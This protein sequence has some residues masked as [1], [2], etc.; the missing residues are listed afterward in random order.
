MAVHLRLSSAKLEAKQALERHLK[1]L[2]DI[3][4]RCIV[5]NTGN[6]GFLYL[7]SIPI[8][9]AAWEGYF[10]IACSICLRRHCRPGQKVSSYTNIY[11]ALWLQKEGFLASFLQKLLNTMTLGTPPKKQGAGKFDVLTDFTGAMKT[12]LGSPVDHLIDFDA[13]VMTHSNVNKSVAELN[14]K[15]I[16]LDI[17]NV[18]LGRLDSLLEQRNSIAHG[19]LI[20]YPTKISVEDTL[21]YSRRVITEFHEAVINWLNSN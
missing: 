12:W 18:S 4:S 11:A 17:S 15:I 10:K 7:M 2:D 8:I 5:L 21:D 3:H 20:T 6:D 19:G 13:L 1:I 14:A 9:Y 16:G